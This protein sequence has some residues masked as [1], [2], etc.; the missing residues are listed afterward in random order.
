MLIPLAYVKSISVGYKIKPSS[1]ECLHKKK[2]SSLDI[3][4]WSKKVESA[5]FIFLSVLA[6]LLSN[7]SSFMRSWFP[8]KTDLTFVGL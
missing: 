7:D 6:S 1:L 2:N 3:N 4:F 5:Y 8:N